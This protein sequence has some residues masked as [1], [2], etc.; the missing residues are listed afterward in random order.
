MEK[1]TVW[2]SDLLGEWGSSSPCHPSWAARPGH[3]LCHNEA[4]QDKGQCWQSAME[5]QDTMTLNWFLFY[6][7][8]IYVLSYFWGWKGHVFF[9]D[10]RC[11]LMSNPFL[12]Y[13]NPAVTGTI[14]LPE[15]NNCFQSLSCLTLFCRIKHLQSFMWANCI[16]HAFCPCECR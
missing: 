13:L 1:H 12:V 8:L 16:C 9:K 3:E 15:W 4:P 14:A 11:S 7:C 6:P 2:K 10:Q 5:K